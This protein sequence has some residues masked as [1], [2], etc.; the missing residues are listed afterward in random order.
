MIVVVPKVSKLALPKIS[1]K[2]KSESN[3]S[4]SVAFKVMTYIDFPECKNRYYEEEWINC[5]SAI[6]E[7]VKTSPKARYGFQTLIE[8]SMEEYR[9]Y[10]SYGEEAL[11]LYVIDKAE[12]NQRFKNMVQECLFKEDTGRDHCINSFIAGCSELNV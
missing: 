10:I 6:T 8:I 5:I 9:K 4:E 1:I 7:K 11:E 12:N 2:Q 3:K